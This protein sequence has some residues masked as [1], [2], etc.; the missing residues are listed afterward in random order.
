LKYNPDGQNKQS[1]FNPPSKSKPEPQVKKFKPSEYNKPNTSP[2][3]K[4]PNKYRPINSLASPERPKRYE[5]AYINDS[6][7]YQRK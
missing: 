3:R 1:S 5:A 7:Y 4:S 6:Y 2:T